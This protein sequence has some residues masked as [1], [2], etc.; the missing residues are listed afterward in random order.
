[1]PR[2]AVAGPSKVVTDA[3]VAIGNDGGSVVDVAL[4]AAITAMCTEP[5]ICGPGGRFIT[6]DVPGHDPIVVDGYMAFPG[7]APRVDRISGRCR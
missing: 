7:R 4:V 6:V 3:A 1:V 2:I 5:G